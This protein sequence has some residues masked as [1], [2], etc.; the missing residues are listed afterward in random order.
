MQFKLGFYVFKAHS[1]VMKQRLV[2]QGPFKA[3]LAVVLCIQGPAKAHQTGVVHI[4]STFAA[5]LQYTQK[6]EAHFLCE[7]DLT[8]QKACFLILLAE[9]AAFVPARVPARVPGG[10]PAQI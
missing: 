10:A 7:V 4:Q 5:F 3:I 6:H 8:G 1:R 9:K 2:F